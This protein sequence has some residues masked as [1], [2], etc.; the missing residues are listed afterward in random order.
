MGSIPRTVPLLADCLTVILSKNNLL[1]LNQLQQIHSQLLTN[2]NLSSTALLTSFLASCYRVQKR[3]NPLLILQTLP[4]PDPLLWNY[5]VRVSL[6][7]NNLQ[8]FLCF[9]NGLRGNNLVPSVSTIS[10]IL[11]SCASLCATQL[12]KS[13]HSQIMK[14]GSVPDVILLTALLDF[15]AKVGDLT[16]AKL[17]FVEMPERDVVANNAMISALSKHGFIEAAQSLFDDMPERDSCSWNSMITSYCKLGQTDVARLMFNRNPVKNVVSWNAIIDG[18]CKLGQIMN[19]EELFVQ[20][21]SIKN[22]VTW[23]T[24]IAGYVQSMEFSKAISVFQQMQAERVEATEVTMASLL[25]ACAHLG[26]LELGERVHAYIRKKNLRVDVVLGNAL[27]DMYCKCGSIEAALRVF[28]GLPTKNIFCWNSI[29]IGLGIHGYGREAI[30]VFVSMDK[31]KVKPDGVTF[32]GLL[33]GC[34]H[35]GLI[36]EGRAGLLEEALQLIKAMPMKPNSV[37]WGSLLQACQVHEDIEFG[38]QVTQYLFELDP[39]DEGNFVFLSN[40]YASLNC[41]DDVS[42]CRR[43]MIARG[44]Q[45][46]PGCSSVELDNIEHEFVVEETSPPCKSHNLLHLFLSKT[47]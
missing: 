28:H 3:H 31:D 19:A 10:L 17:V 41:W 38:M 11:R 40:L 34:T 24:M 6:E 12:G 1:S 42:I 8:D 32:I 2:G 39:S 27:I 46:T 45:K 4:N 15:Y 18:Y 20:M 25:S 44:M 30:D 23:N 29:I 13:F 37:V 43:L 35:S 7:S 47:E 16:S 22:T 33:S 9:Y 26:V 5:M 36:A 21:G 14:M